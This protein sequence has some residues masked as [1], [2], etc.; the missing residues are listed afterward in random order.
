M[1]H[2]I[3]ISLSNEALEYCKFK[4][5]G[6]SKLFKRALDLHVHIEKLGFDGHD[7]SIFPEAIEKQR[8]TIEFL[9][10]EIERRNERIESL[11][12]VLARQEIKK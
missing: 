11:T 3:S 7:L 2:I 8:A 6:K 12:D 9:Q 10:T 1:S 4:G 5:I